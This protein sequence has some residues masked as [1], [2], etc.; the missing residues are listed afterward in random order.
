MRMRGDNSEG[1][2]VGLVVTLPL[3]DG[4]MREHVLRTARAKLD[5]AVEQER[6]VQQRIARDVNNAALMLSAAT[7][8]VEASTK[9]LEQA[10]EESRVVRERFQAGRGIQ[11]EVLDAQVLL[12]RARFNAVNALADYH[13]AL[14]MW[15]S[16]LGRVR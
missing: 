15:L 9:G 3:F 1:Y 6:I 14:A 4:F 10:D 12:T 16:A 8:S 13:S 11:L 7:K 5:R 2:S